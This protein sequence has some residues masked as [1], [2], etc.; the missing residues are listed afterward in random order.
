MLYFWQ[1]VSCK[2]A[3][4]CGNTVNSPCYSILCLERLKVKTDKRDNLDERNQKLACK[5]SFLQKECCLPV[6]E[7]SVRRALDLRLVGCMFKFRFGRSIW[8]NFLSFCFI[9]C[10]SPSNIT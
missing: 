8:D 3:S 1:E 10:P 5:T 2:K 9:C 6:T 7:S 4:W